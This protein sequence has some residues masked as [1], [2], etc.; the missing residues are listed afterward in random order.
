[1]PGK[2][3]Q[4]FIIGDHWGVRRG[5]VPIFCSHHDGG[6][7]D[8]GTAFSVDHWHSMITA[9]HVLDDSQALPTYAILAHGGFGEYRVPNDLIARFQRLDGRRVKLEDPLAELSNQERWAA[10]DVASVA[11]YPGYDQSAIACLPI[12]ACPKPLNVGDWVVALG[13]PGLEPGKK[14]PDTPITRMQLA[15][16]FGRVTKLFPNGRSSDATPVFEVDG[17]W[18]GGMSGGP[19]LDQA[20]EVV[21]IVH[22]GIDPGDGHPGTSWGVWFERLGINELVPTID[23]WHPEVRRC[24]ATVVDNRPTEIFPD[25]ES[26]RSRGD[27]HGEEVRKV[28]L[29]LGTRQAAAGW[30]ED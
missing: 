29:K 4:H 2:E 20:G 19:I 15:R 30:D 8:L 22:R 3:F 9:Y 7:Q 14:S 25:F 23:N 21:G 28:R 13:F 11:L 12:R 18:S 16:A 24:W 27:A 10:F 1:M 6:W 26:A 5:V 17:H